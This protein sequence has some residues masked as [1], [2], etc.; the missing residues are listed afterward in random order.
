MDGSSLGNPGPATRERAIED[1]QVKL[2]VA[3]S[4]FYGH[5]TSLE[6]KVNALLDG[7]NPVK[8]YGISNIQIGLDSLLLVNSLNSLNSL[9][10]HLG[11]L[12]NLFGRIGITYNIYLTPFLIVIENQTL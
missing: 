4:N 10:S 1:S 5:L 8:D 11:R 3:F 9:S 2:V 7:L 6:T 12:C